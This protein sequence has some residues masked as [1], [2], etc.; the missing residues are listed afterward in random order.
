[1]HGFI[2]DP[3]PCRGRLTTSR[4]SSPFD[5]VRIGI[6]IP[7]ATSCAAER[8]PFPFPG[9]LWEQVQNGEVKWIAWSSIPWSR[10]IRAARVLSSPPERRM[11]AFR[12]GE[13]VA[14]RFIRRISVRDR[15]RRKTA[16][17]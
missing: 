1:M 13:R 11:T 2:A 9:P 6:P 5:T 14:G 4:Y 8:H 10:T 12:A 3:R 16:A 7:T 17:P 15:I